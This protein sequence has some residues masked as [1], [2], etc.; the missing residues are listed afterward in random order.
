MVD[1]HFNIIEKIGKNAYNLEL[2]NNFDILLTSNVK[3]L[4]SYHGKDLR[5]SLFFPPMGD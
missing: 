4:R 1:G 3:N 5:D 2:P